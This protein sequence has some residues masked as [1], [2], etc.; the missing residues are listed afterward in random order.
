MSRFLLGGY[1]VTWNDVTDD[2]RCNYTFVHGAFSGWLEEARGIH[3]FW[4]HDPNLRLA[5]Q[6]VGLEV[7]EDSVGLAWQADIECRRLPHVERQ[8]V[9]GAMGCSVGA[10]PLKLRRD[11]FAAIDPRYALHEITRSLVREIS[12]TPT[13][14]YPTA[15]CWFRDQSWWELRPNVQGLVERWRAGRPQALRPRYAA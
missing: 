6:G 4:D 12:L 14:A 3:L 11:P 13:P 10:V 1:G 7:W 9:A 5:S 8:I 2:A 15:R